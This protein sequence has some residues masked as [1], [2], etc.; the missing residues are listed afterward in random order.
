MLLL[1]FRVFASKKNYAKVLANRGQLVVINK[2]LKS[3]NMV[4]YN[5]LKILASEQ[6]IVFSLRSKIIKSRDIF[7]KKYPDKN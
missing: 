5:L 4:F 1:A 3:S 6:K 2:L 7:Y